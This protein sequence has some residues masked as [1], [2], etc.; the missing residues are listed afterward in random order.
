MMFTGTFPGSDARSRIRAAAAAIAIILMA[1]A[2][3]AESCPDTHYPCGS[4]L[5]CPK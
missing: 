1:T 5:C 2:V 3:Y 4:N